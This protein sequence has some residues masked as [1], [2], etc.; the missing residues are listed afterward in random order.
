MFMLPFNILLV[1]QL[2][3]GHRGISGTLYQSI[4]KMTMINTSFSDLTLKL[5]YN[6][7]YSLHYLHSSTSGISTLSIDLDTKNSKHEG[8]IAQGIA[9]VT[10][11]G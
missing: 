11:Y 2:L 3:D 5:W 4:G 9:W 1:V 6:G 7:V 8:G 10:L